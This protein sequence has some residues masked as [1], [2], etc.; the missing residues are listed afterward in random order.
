MK[1]KNELLTA[2]Q[3]LFENRADAGRQLASALQAY[4]NQKT[5]VLAIP[6]GGV[7]LAIPVAEAL[8]AELDIIICRKLALP[9]NQAGGLGAVADD[10]TSII[11]QDVVERD[12][13]SQAQVEHELN[14]VKANI[15][16][17]S[18]LYKGEGVSPRMTGKTVILVDDGLA[19]GITMTVAVEAVRHRRPKQI[20]VAIPLAS[21]TGYNRVSKVA[22][23][24][25]VCAVANLSRFYLADFY[26]VW[27]DISDS[28]V[29]LALKQWRQRQII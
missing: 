28:E 4:S 26:R 12:G 22:D 5:V 18:A 23:A 15:K 25:V 27:R 20:I 19:S 24:V 2:S 16:Q 6:N 14:E 8:Q 17:R 10:G 1:I 21:Q 9:M 3:I 11:N 29:A 13:I 7:P